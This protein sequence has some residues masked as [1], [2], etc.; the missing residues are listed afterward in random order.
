M[1]GINPEII[2]GPIMNNDLKGNIGTFVSFTL[3]IEIR[4]CIVSE[5]K[6]FNE[7][8]HET[9]KWNFSISLGGPSCRLYHISVKYSRRGME[10]LA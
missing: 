7:T 1:L 3:D 9:N 4:P 6:G 8:R 2:V 5:K 10:G